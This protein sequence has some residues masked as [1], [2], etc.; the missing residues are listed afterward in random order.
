MAK[1]FNHFQVIF[2]GGKVEPS[3]DT[4]TIHLFQGDTPVGVL[5]RQEEPEKDFDREGIIHFHADPVTFDYIFEILE[6]QINVHGWSIDL[7]GE[8]A[9][10]VFD[11]P[12]VK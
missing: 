10:I 3:S 2:L 6:N 1:I 5:Y 8:R 12:M 9:K 11:L 7:E 4:I